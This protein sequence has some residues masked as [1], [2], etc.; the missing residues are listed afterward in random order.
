MDGQ[1]N[2]RAKGFDLV[3]ILGVGGTSRGGLGVF[4][5]AMMR[6]RPRKIAGSASEALEIHAPIVLCGFAM[7]CHGSVRLTRHH[8]FAD[9]HAVCAHGDAHLRRMPSR[10]RVSGGGSMRSD[11]T[12]GA[13]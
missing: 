12:S 9:S 1:M 6:K 3:R 7:A 10:A 4:G 13:A 11:A 8:A 2:G 5:S